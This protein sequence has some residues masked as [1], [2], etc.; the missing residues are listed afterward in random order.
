MKNITTMAIEHFKSYPHFV[1]NQVLKCS[2]LN[3]SFGF[4]DEQARLS[5]VHLV[6]QGI[7]NGLEVSLANGVLTIGKGVALDNGGWVVQLTEDSPYSYAAAVPFSNAPFDSDNLENLVINGGG[8]VKYICFKTEDDA[9]ELGLK[10]I[11]LA[12]VPTKDLVIAL[13][14]G[15]RRELSNRCSHDSCDI[16]V[17]SLL[18]E[19]WPVLVKTP[20]RPLYAYPKAY[21]VAFFPFAPFGLHNYTDI[22]KV[23]ETIMDVFRQRRDLVVQQL[24]DILQNLFGQTY[25]PNKVQGTAF[26]SK[27]SVWDHVFPDSRR[28]FAR[29]RGSIVK[30]SQYCLSQKADF[31]P[32]YYLSFLNDLWQATSEFVEDYNEFVAETVRIPDWTPEDR[33]T[34]LG[35]LSVA[36]DNQY[37]SFFQKADAFDSDAGARRLGRMLRRIVILSEHFFGTPS[38]INLAKKQLNLVSVRP[39]SRLSEKPIPF[40][41]R[42]SLTTEFV[43]NWNADKKSSYRN[44]PDYENSESKNKRKDALLTPQTGMQLYLEAYQ[45]KD[46]NA[47]KNTLSSQQWLSWMN[48]TIK[49][50][51]FKPIRRQTPAQKEFLE[52]YYDVEQFKSYYEQMCQ[53]LTGTA[54]DV[55]H[56]FY[57]QWS[58]GRRKKGFTQFSSRLTGLKK[59]RTIRPKPAKTLEESLDGLWEMTRAFKNAIGLDYVDKRNKYADPVYSAFL[60]LAHTLIDDVDRESETPLQNSVLGGPVLPNSTLYLLVED[61]MVFSYA[62]VY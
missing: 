14:Y 10:P 57:N 13:V 28:L 3:N 27:A 6:G 45:F 8:S 40:Y 33:F 38:H 11:P 48:I 46:K 22:K 4:L 17:T 29:L 42:A 59:Y 30:L 52:K 54:L 55:A 39:G 37:R 43:E 35:R 7:L 19:A 56:S 51:E 34:F 60:S 58:D 5:R 24:K 21:D 50:L 12:E 23:N 1:A 9:L 31:V 15:T 2:D 47:V 49:T 18:V 61:N 32:D 44:A 41:Y 36:N 26:V 16:N 62:V 53:N 20:P 25:V